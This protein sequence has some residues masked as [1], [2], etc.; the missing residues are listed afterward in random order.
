M[1]AIGWGAAFAVLLAAGPG[2]AEKA[3]DHAPQSQIYQGY[4]ED[5]QVADRPLSDWEGDWQSVYPL[6][7]DG[8]LD[9]VMAHKAEH[10]DKSAEAYK[11]YYETG[12]RTD[13]ERI[14]IHGDT[15]SF[16]RGDAV[17]TGDYVAD[18]HEILT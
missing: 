8:T 7:A 4:F 18:G 11:A 5:S 1:R 12:Y 6:L 14:E 10:G 9:P 16:Y 3:H 17:A 15:V 2:L 13:V